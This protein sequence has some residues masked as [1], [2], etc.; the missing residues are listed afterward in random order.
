RGVSTEYIGIP[1]IP[2]PLKPAALLIGMLG[3]IGNLYIEIELRADV[4]G[5][6]GV[7]RIYR[8]SLY[9]PPPK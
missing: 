8:D 6:R 9:T 5:Q 1:Y 7:Y 2:P 4:S 3:R